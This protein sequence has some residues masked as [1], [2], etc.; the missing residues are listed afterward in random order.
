[1]NK[2]PSAILIMGS[3]G[4]GKSTYCLSAFPNIEVLSCD[5]IREKTFGYSRSYEIR[6]AVREMLIDKINLMVKNKTTFAIDST[7]FNLK[8]DRALLI[9]LL[10]GY[11]IKVIFVHKSLDTCLRQNRLRNIERIIS[12]DMIIKLHEEIDYPNMDEGFQEI[13]L[14][15]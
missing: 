8:K 6:A 7:Y 13:F 9:N 10:A 1:M 11:Y 4:A 3:P 14:I 12:D 2:L 15:E 5:E